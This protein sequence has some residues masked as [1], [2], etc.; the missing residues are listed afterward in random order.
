MESHIKREIG[1]EGIEPI[2]CGLNKIKIDEN[3]N[4]VTLNEED[5]VLMSNAEG[6][7]VDDQFVKQNESE[8]NPDEKLKEN[9][10]HL[11]FVINQ[12]LIRELINEIEAEDQPL[13]F[14]RR[15][16]INREKRQK[17][18]IFKNLLSTFDQINCSEKSG[19]KG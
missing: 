14:Q 16:K 17:A 12:D 15:A 10:Q 19:C 9:L 2:V 6:V 8:K 3:G 1:L 18:A 7:N 5:M 13:Q 4:V 11:V